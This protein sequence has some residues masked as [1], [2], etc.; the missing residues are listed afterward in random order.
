R[1]ARGSCVELEGSVPLAPGGELLES[2]GRQLAR[3]LAEQVVVGPVRVEDERFDGELRQVVREDHVEPFG[4]ASADPGDQQDR[5]A[6]I[7]DALDSLLEP[8]WDI[9]STVSLSEL[10]IDCAPIEIFE[11]F[12]Q[13]GLVGFP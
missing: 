11:V 12:E 9:A 2:L 6:A 13:P 7:A 10:R 3:R 8:A 4:L 5:V 1:T